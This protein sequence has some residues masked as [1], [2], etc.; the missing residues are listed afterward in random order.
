MEREFKSLET[1]LDAKAATGIG[2]TLDVS[3]FKFIVLEVATASN[4][5]LT[6]KIQG[7]VS[8]ARPTFSSAASVSNAWSYVAFYNY[9]SGSF[10][11]GDTGIVYSGTD[12]VELITVNVD[13]LKWLNVNVT[14]RSAGSITIKAIGVNN[15]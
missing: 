10:V 15:G 5:A 3:Q 2:T 13:F 7:S 12:S 11:A 4:A 9:N 6:A 1:I 14:A 8:D